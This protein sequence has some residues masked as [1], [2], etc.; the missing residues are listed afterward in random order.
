MKGGLD[1]QGL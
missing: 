1:S